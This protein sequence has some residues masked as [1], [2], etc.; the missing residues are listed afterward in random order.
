[1]IALTEKILAVTSVFI[2]S[3]IAVTGYSGIAIP[4]GHSSLPAFLF[5]LS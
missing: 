2:K 1:L 5:H 3:T 4:D